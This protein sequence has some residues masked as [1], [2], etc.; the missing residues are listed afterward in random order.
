[1]C[2]LEQC[3]LP[4]SL[5]LHDSARVGSFTERNTLGKT[6]INTVGNDNDRSYRRNG[7]NKQTRGW[8]SKVSV[9]KDIHVDAI[10]EGSQNLTIV[11]YM[12]TLKES[13]KKLMPMKLRVF[14]LS[15][16]L[17]LFFPLKRNSLSTVSNNSICSSS[18]LSPLINSSVLL[19]H[20]KTTIRLC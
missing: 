19:N 17:L 14:R 9:A 1:M 11:Q 15:F 20:S 2:P 4:R 13:S 5:K 12:N 10:N 8:K 16:M 6:M 3:I 18:K 7:T